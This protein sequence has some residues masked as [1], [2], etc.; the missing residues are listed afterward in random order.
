MN[1]NNERGINREMSALIEVPRGVDSEGEDEY[2]N[3]SNTD[4]K[5]YSEYNTIS[6]ESEPVSNSKILTKME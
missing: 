2:K 4:G 6:I 5:Y 3:D 1:A